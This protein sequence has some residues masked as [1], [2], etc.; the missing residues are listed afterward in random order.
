MNTNNE[1]DLQADQ[2]MEK[3]EG[4]WNCKVCGKKSAKK[5][6]IKRHTETHMEGVS[7]ACHNCSKTFSTRNNLRIHISR[8]HSELVSCDVCGKSGMNSGTYSI[9]KYKYHK[10]LSVNQ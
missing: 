3:N 4:M 10:T 2:M 9:H 8:I 5:Q 6:M 7:H 1:V